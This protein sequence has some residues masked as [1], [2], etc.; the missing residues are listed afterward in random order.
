V[1]S[2]G[3]GNSMTVNTFTDNS[4]GT[5]PAATETFQVGATLNVGINQAAGAYST[6]N[7]GGTPYTIT[8]NYN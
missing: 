4:S 7:A 5:L 2:D 3:G 1:L 8:A 6:A